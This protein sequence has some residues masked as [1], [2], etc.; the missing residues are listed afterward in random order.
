M[1][2]Q[3][4]SIPHAAPTATEPRQNRLISVRVSQVEEVNAV[5][6]LFRLTLP[7]DEV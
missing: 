2:T 7:D 6:R 5:V 4:D 1:S 3:H